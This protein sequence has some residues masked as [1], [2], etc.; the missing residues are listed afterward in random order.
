MGETLFGCSI[1]LVVAA[2]GFAAGVYTRKARRRRISAL[3]I[4]R[5]IAESRGTHTVDA[6]YQVVK[7]DIPIRQRFVIALIGAIPR[8][9]CA[10]LYLAIFGFACKN[11]STPGIVFAAV[12]LAF[13]LIFPED[14]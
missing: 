8:F 1:F 14:V 10:G 3:E 4:A 5:Q 9:T 12:A 11:S 13:I 2:T 7:H 6:V